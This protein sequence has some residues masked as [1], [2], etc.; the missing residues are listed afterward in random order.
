MPFV[1]LI[2]LDRCRRGGGTFVERDGFGLAVFWLADP[3]RVM[4]IDDECPH[5]GGSLASGKVDGDSVAC[6]WHQWEFDLS[7]GVS[8]HSAEAWVRRY[9]TEV[10]DG[11]VWVDLPR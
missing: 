1:K 6:P 8:T 5:A 7:T 2:P 11:V 4:V 9:P 3:E 10:R